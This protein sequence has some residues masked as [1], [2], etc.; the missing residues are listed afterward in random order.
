MKTS[1]TTK[2]LLIALVCFVCSTSASGEGR[3]LS[4]AYEVS[5]ENFQPPQSDNGAATFK[6]C[7]DC[8]VRRVQVTASTRYAVNGRA[9]DLEEFRLALLQTKDREG[10]SI[11]VL[12]HLESNSVESVDAWL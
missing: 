7:A 11:T 5:V 12:H 2:T 4:Q 6:E 9:V 1:S 3:V 10:G 8:D